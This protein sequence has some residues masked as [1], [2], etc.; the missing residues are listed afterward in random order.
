MKPAR[1]TTI[2][3]SV[4]LI[5]CLS[6]VV[7]T[8]GRV[9]RLRSGASLQEILYI[10]S[11]KVLKRL[12]L[13][14]EGLLADVY[15]TRAVQY[16]GNKHRG[17]VENY[18]LLAPLLEITTYL[19][20]HLMV[21]YEYGANFLA[22]RPPLGAGMPER[23]VQLVESGIRANPDSWKLYNSL[24]FIYYFEFKD[25]GKAAEA[26]NT[27]SKISGAHP[28]MKIVAAN[29][30]QHAGDFG[31]ARMLWTTTFESTN[32]KQ[33]KYNAVAHLRALKVEEDVTNLEKLVS[34]YQ[35]TTGHVPAH[36]SDFVSAGILPGIP[37]DPTGHPYKVMPDGTIQ[38]RNPD[39]FPFI[40]K[41]LPPG[42]QPLALDFS[43]M[44][45]ET[46]R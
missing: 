41:G 44:K 12:S 8:L 23:A 30:A 42:Y 18:R 20:P 13:G 27:G 17:Y 1:R 22:P 33:I 14:Y 40:T 46:P 2:I 35:E 4:L 5:A 31:M 37:V 16:F 6:G 43:K 24:G 38:V 29:M 26:F 3:A 39:D 9:D 36:L 7:F 21:A 34:L 10:S 11:P 15:W 25:Y 28:F 32:D 19:D 45:L